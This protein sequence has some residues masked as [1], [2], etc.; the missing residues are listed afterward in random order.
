MAQCAGSIW[1]EEGFMKSKL[2]E[3]WSEELPDNQEQI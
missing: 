1:Y 3:E 2:G